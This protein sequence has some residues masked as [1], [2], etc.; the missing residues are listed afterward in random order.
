MLVNIKGTEQLF[1]KGEAQDDHLGGASTHEAMV[2]KLLQHF[3]S[4]FNV[5][6]VF[7]LSHGVPQGCLGDGED[8]GELF[9]LDKDG[10]SLAVP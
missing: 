8:L 1:S 4:V 10:A 3:S 6:S 5:V 2:S 9:K 7:E